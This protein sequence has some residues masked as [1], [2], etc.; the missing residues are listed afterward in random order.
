M[1]SGHKLAQA[2]TYTGVTRY[3]LKTRGPPKQSYS[4][5][6]EDVKTH[7]GACRV[8]KFYKGGGVFFCVWGGSLS[9]IIHSLCH[10]ASAYAL[11]L[12]PSRVSPSTP[13]TE[14]SIYITTG[15]GPGFM[16]AANKG[17]AEVRW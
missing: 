4:V 17:A 1:H 13:Q 5:I 2:R 6:D 11:S 8:Y 16:E 3:H 12:P 15:G 7:P 14:Q 10:H 9:C